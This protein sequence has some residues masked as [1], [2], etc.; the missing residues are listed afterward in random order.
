MIKS[1]FTQIILQT[2]CLGVNKNLY[3]D[4]CGSDH[5]STSNDTVIR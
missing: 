3:L 4:P 2:L 1:T 5:F